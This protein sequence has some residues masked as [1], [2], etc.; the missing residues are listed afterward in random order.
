MMSF[1]IGPLALPAAP[2]LLLVSTFVAMWLANRMAA[3]VS[4]E[5]APSA[6]SAGD[7]LLQSIGFGLLV[8][9][10]THIGAHHQAYVAEPWAVIDLRD[11][12]WNTWVGLVSGVGF[13]IWR[14]RRLPHWRKAL[15]TGTAAG[16]T[17]WAF[18]ILML[19]TV[20]PRDVP[21]VEVQDLVTGE[22]V[23]LRKLATNKPVVLNLWASWCGPC[24]SEMPV[25]AAA[26]TRHPDVVFIFANQGE[27]AQTV[28]QYL[29]AERLELTH[30]ALDR[31][32]RLG[33]A[34]GSSGLPTTVFFN[35][36]GLRMDAHMGALNAAALESKII[37]ILPR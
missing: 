24:R 34:L 6:G 4:Q 17:L 16:L 8:S 32:S 19:V 30:V 13:I 37:S 15:A 3:Q 7:L 22:V 35:Q 27:A 25:L 2:A 10:V 1:S 23:S 11:G 20:T 28:R 12:G 18:G 9:R 26:Q 21:D 33:P 36:E 29:A 5:P 31:Q 14:A